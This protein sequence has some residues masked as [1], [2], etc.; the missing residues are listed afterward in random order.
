[1][2]YGRDY[3]IYMDTLKAMAAVGPERW[4]GIPY[5]LPGAGKKGAL[6]SASCHETNVTKWGGACWSLQDMTKSDL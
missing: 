3:R 1:M 2:G 6:R 4:P 5:E